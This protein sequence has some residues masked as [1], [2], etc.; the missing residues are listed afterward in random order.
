MRAL[1]ANHSRA[2]AGRFTASRNQPQQLQTEPASA[3]ASVEVSS[4][5]FDLLLIFLVLRQTPTQSQ[6]RV[7]RAQ[8]PESAA[9]LAAAVPNAT[10][11]ESALSMAFLPGGM[12]PA[13]AAAAAPSPL[14]L[15]LQQQMFQAQS[16]LQQHK[17]ENERLNQE[18]QN[19]SLARERERMQEQRLALERGMAL[20]SSKLGIGFAPNLDASQLQLQPQRPPDS[21]FAAMQARLEKLEV[22]VTA[23]CL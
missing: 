1:K 22:S 18:L 13:S 3:S 23:F 20:L 9:T 2:S 17:A 5:T 21:D 6:S 7:R 16:M 12:S 14:W 11:V 10:A 8:L 15:Q 19:M 4:L